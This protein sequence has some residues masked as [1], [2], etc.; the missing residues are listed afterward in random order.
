MDNNMKY[1]IQFAMLSQLLK[2]NLISNK[3]YIAIKNELMRKYRI[4][5]INA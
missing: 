4:K 1:S 5:M 3:E 2:L